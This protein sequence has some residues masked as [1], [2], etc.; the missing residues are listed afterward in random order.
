[1]PDESENKTS[2]VMISAVFFSVQAP[3]YFTDAFYLSSLLRLLHLSCVLAASILRLS[4]FE[5]APMLQPRCVVV[6]VS[7]IEYY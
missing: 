5:V 7:L 4:T 1:M 3:R 2:Q 6:A